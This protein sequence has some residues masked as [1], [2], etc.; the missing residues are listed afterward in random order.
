[1]TTNNHWELEKEMSVG[2]KLPPI[3]S[4]WLAGHD[5]ICRSGPLCRLTFVGGNW[6]TGAKPLGPCCLGAVS[7][8]AGTEMVLK[9]LQNLDAACLLYYGVGILILI[10]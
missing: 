3:C 7:E 10:R 1:M 5:L 8:G 2:M 9:T 6:C 4:F